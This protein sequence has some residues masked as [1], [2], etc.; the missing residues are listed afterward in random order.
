MCSLSRRVL[1]HNRQYI[2]KSRGT[3][4][5]WS[6]GEHGLFG[7]A[8]GRSGSQ[9]TGIRQYTCSTDWLR[10]VPWITFS[11]L[12]VLSQEPSKGG[13]VVRAGAAERARVR[14]SESAP[15]ETLITYM[16]GHTEFVYLIALWSIRCWKW[17]ASCWMTWDL[18]FLFQ[19]QKHFSGYFCET[20]L[21]ILL[22]WETTAA[23]LTCL[24]FIF[25]RRFL[26][27][28]QASRKVRL[29]SDFTATIFIWVMHKCLIWALSSEVYLQ[30]PSMTLGFLA[31]YLAELTLTEYEFLKFLP[32]LVAASAVFLA[33]WTLDQSDLPWVRIRNTW[34]IQ[35]HMLSNI[36][37]WC[38]PWPVAVQSCAEPDS[39]ALHLLQM[40]WHSIVCLCP[41]GT[42]A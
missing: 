12:T 6:W 25:I 38:Y 33:R 8:L 30:T 18:T 23:L 2:H 40:L 24:S 32:S 3:C 4:F 28:A 36:F 22:K 21:V 19:Q 16:K 15:K 42:P 31:N 7:R 41:T 29:A 39:R 5:M 20:C 37:F 34:H 11:Q 17:R 9:P 26:R 35:Q 27:A 13:S 10:L 14:A 1:F